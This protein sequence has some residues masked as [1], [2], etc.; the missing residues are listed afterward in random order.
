MTKPEM[1]TWQTKTDCAT[2][3]CGDTQADVT[4]WANHEGVTVGVTGLHGANVL[5]GSLRWEQMEALCAAF[6]LLKARGG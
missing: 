4:A 1:E 5:A 2:V 3:R 6:A